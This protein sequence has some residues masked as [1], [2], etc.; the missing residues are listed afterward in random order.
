MVV[1][2]FNPSKQ[3]QVDFFELEA[4][5]VDMVNSR[6]VRASLERPSLGKKVLV[7]VDRLLSI[8]CA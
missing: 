4:S 8:S 2:T 1:C 5:P 3:R 7:T 6:M